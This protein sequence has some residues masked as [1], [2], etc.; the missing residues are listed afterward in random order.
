MKTASEIIKSNDE[1]LEGRTDDRRHIT[2]TVEEFKTVSAEF[3]RLNDELAA[4]PRV[5][6][7]YQ[8]RNDKIEGKY[9]KAVKFLKDFT[10]RDCG[11]SDSVHGCGL[12]TDAFNG[13]VD[14]VEDFLI[15]LGV[16]PGIGLIK[17]ESPADEVN[18][19]AQVRGDC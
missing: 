17:K 2:L 8:D 12:F 15:E 4:C 11:C 10:E 19:E 9:F 1:W 7:L 16:K 5:V 3:S 18:R 6:K 13:F 14:S